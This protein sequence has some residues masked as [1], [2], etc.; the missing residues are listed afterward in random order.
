MKSIITT[1]TICMYGIALSA[2][3]ETVTIDADSTRQ[4]IEGFGATT[5]PL[6]YGSQDNLG[7]YRA[8]ALAKAYND[9]KLTMGNISAGNIEMDSSLV[10]GT[11]TNDDNDPFNY[12]WSGFNF[13]YS[14]ND[15]QYL[16]N[17]AAQYG[18]N[19]FMIESKINH[20]WGTTWMPALRSS[21]YNQYLDECAEYVLAVHKYWRD[22]LGI[23]QPYA[24]IFNEPLTGNGE[25]NGGTV[26]EVVDI[27]KRVGDRFRAEGFDSIMIIAPNEETL[28][29]TLT[30]VTAILAD[31]AARKYIGAIGYHTYP[32]GSPY[33]EASNILAQ[34]GTGNP[35]A[36]EINKR[37]QLKAMCDSFNIPLWF[38]EV[39]CSSLPL[40]SMDLLRGRAIH[41]HDEMLYAGVSAYFGMNT[42]WDY[43]SQLDHFGSGAGFNNEAEIVQ[44]DSNGVSRITSTGYAI[45]HYA[46]WLQKGAKRVES[47][48]S[49]SLVQISS[50]KDESS[51]K[52]TVIAINNNSV[53]KTVQ[54]DFSGI[55]LIDSV[56]GEQSYDSTR[57]ESI[58]P[59]T[60]LSNQFSYTLLPNSVTS[61]GG[62]F[63]IPTGIN[64]IDRNNFVS[65]S[66]NPANSVIE[67]KIAGTS[68][69]ET[70]HYVVEIFNTIG[71]KVL[72][73]QNESIINV[74]N[75]VSGMYFLK[76]R[77]ENKFL[78]KI[79]VKQ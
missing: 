56:H 6:V 53:S 74:S 14:K 58:P 54:F 38:T 10:F 40:F 20:R 71:E 51:N 73:S 47:T 23:V 4:T 48:S 22:S 44:I 5:L 68:K 43:Q 66:P 41:I 21:N 37:T 52:F 75:L 13:K 70:N 19:N 57:W 46:R 62:T 42:L 27:I 28:T 61:F 60:P 55:N 11:S 79:F 49:D 18:F 69:S 76:I 1:I 15:I 16:I 65:V 67:I 32:Y 35:D 29:Q 63:S 31:S 12:D 17:P 77:L 45:G 59:V 7:I 36:N 30:D 50:F 26:Q 33:A 2:Q 34:S 64:H 39:C 78:T 9:V 8:D 72:Q 24:M 25:L 3:T